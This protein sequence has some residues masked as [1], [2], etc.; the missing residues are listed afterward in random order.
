M[1]SR[2]QLFRKSPL[3]VVPAPGESKQRRRRRYLRG[4]VILA[5]L[6]A[7]FLA[8]LAYR[9]LM[10]PI[11][12]DYFPLLRELLDLGEAAWAF[13][14]TFLWVG[15][16]WRHRTRDRVTRSVKRISLEGLYQLSP[17]DFEEYVG[18]L[19]RR[20]G[21]QV[22]RRGGSGDHGVDL[23]LFGPDGRKAIVQCKRY[24]HT[25]GEEIVRELFGTIIHERSIRGFLVTTAEISA[26]A[27]SWA[28]GKPITLIDGPTLVEIAQSLAKERY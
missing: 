13:T 15:L 19:F 28:A 27:K 3:S 18:T 5:F 11:W 22:A 26:S 8:W 10:K 16:W 6:T 17:K 4:W 2:F 25:V 23:E 21:Y 24:Q 7:V 20:K 12:P 14:L 9:L 1:L